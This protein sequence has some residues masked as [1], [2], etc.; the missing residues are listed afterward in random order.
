MAYL[1][2]ILQFILSV[3]FL[4]SFTL[5]LFEIFR[6]PR[7]FSFLNKQDQKKER[8]FDEFDPS[9]SFI[10]SMSRLENYVDTLYK[11]SNHARN[12]PPAYVELVSDVIRKRFYHGVSTYGA[13]RNYVAGAVAYF[14]GINLDAIVLPDDILKYPYALCSQQSLVMMKLL[15]K[16]GYNYRNVCFY[17][18]ETGAGHYAFEIQYNNKWHFFDPDMEPDTRLLEKFNS[19]T[20]SAIVNNKALLL[21]SYHFWDRDQII[22]LFSGYSYGIP[23]APIAPRATIF[24]KI[25]YVLSYSL[26][27]FFFFSFVWITRRIP[28]TEKK[29]I[30]Q[31]SWAFDRARLR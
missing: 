6:I 11:R 9:L 1:K 31:P 29:F 15:K 25:T 21:G 19:P 30:A 28:S 12:D 7:S 17:S 18:K 26:W 3:L 22:K 20:I 4:I 2:R 23:N 27:L 10:N 5:T 24:Q 13:G 8:S 14:S 16:K